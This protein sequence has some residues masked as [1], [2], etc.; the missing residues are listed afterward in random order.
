MIKK[1]IISLIGISSLVLFAGCTSTGISA[2]NLYWGD[3]S[4]TLYELKK[5]PGADTKAAHIKELNSIIEKS[6]ELNLRVPPGL[7]AELGMYMLNEGKKNKANVYFNLELK[8][9]PESKAMVRQ[10]LKKKKS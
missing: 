6:K 1:I 10:I 3:Y 9:Y 7:Y 2:S 8:T 5:S 4:T